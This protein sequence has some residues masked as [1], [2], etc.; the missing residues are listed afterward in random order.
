MPEH[1][2]LPMFQSH[3]PK[4]QKRHAWQ[5]DYHHRR[6]SC[7]VRSTLVQDQLYEQFLGEY[8]I[9]DSNG[10]QILAHFCQ[11]LQP[12]YGFP[13]YLSRPLYQQLL[14]RCDL[15]QQLFYSVLSPFG[16]TFAN[17]Q[18]PAGWLLRERD[19]DQCIVG[20][21]HHLL[22]EPRVHPRFYRKVFSEWSFYSPVC[23][24]FKLVGCQSVFLIVTRRR[25]A[26][27]KKA[28]R[29]S[30]VVINIKK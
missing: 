25:L 23:C 17:L 8:R 5:Y 27:L 14:E 22:H 4:H 29:Q 12:E 28:P 20:K 7:Q 16:Q 2:Q 21:F 15:E 1:A 26:N 13:R 9:L 19:G 30:S 6:P 10:P 11:V 18:K 24:K 3:V